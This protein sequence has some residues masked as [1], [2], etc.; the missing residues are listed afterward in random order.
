MYVVSSIES[1]A[2]SAHLMKP[3]DRSFDNPA[4]GSEAAAMIRSPFRQVR[5]DPALQQLPAMRLRIVGS[6]SLH[7]LGTMAWSAAFATN[8][9]N[10]VHEREQLSDIVGIGGGQRGR[11]GN[12]ICVGD[13]V[14]LAAGFTAICRARPR[15]F[16]PCTARTD[17][18]STTAR[19]Q[20]IL[21]AACSL[22][23]KV[24][25]IRRQTPCFCQACRRRQAVIPEHQPSS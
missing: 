6:I 5:L 17:E 15:F 25:W 22:A 16:P 19:D 20:S 8:L 13:Q 12:S 18:E 11:E 4:C 1:G 9:W 10:G 3:T 23:S 2:Q 24:S 21:S 7:S 14:V